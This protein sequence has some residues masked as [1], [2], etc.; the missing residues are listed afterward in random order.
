NS[1][2]LRRIAAAMDSAMEENDAYWEDS[3][4]DMQHADE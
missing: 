2:Q 1:D 3:E 4:E